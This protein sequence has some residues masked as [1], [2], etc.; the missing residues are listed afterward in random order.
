MKE[1]LQKILSHAGVCSRRKAEELI[2]AGRVRVNGRVVRELGTEADV[3]TD[4]IEALGEI[5][6]PEPLR[7]YLF[8]KPDRVITSVSDPAGRRTVM[9]YFRRVRERVFPVGRLDYHS[10]GLLLVTNDG[11]LDFILTHPRH[12]VQKEYEVVVRGKFSE[13]LAKKMEEGVKIDSGVTAPVKSKCSAMTRK[14]IKQ[15]SAWYSMRKN[16]EIRKMMESS[17]IR[18]FELKRIRYSFLTLDV[19]RGQ[20]RRLTA[21]EVKNLYE[22]HR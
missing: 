13:K 5:V 10:E 6:K 20:Y 8:H 7:Y 17:T 11:Q 18:F 16:R 21:A 22:L 3:C 19:N 4:K 1:R 9:D 14:R 2:L 15:G 12:E